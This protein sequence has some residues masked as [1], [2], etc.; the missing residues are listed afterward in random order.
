M[1]GHKI[2]LIS[3]LAVALFAGTTAEA[4]TWRRA[5]VDT[6]TFNIDAGGTVVIDAQDADISLVGE[7]TDRVE[8]EVEIAARDLER[9]Q[10]LFKRATFEATADRNSLT[11][12]AGP[13]PSRGYRSEARYSMHIRIKTPRRFDIDARTDD[14]DVSI[15]NIA[16]ALKVLSSDGDL[17]AIDIAGQTASLR[18][19]DGDVRIENAKFSTVDLK[20]SDGDIILRRVES[21]KTSAATSDGDI[22]IRLPKGMGAD[23]DLRGEDVVM[24]GVADF[25]GKIKTSSAKG[26][27]NGGG[28]RIVAK[29]KDGTVKFAF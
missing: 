9:A 14:G 6:R 8:I 26:T 22:D 16:G 1:T 24:S 10:A 29:T 27:L 17:R 13:P 28:A 7:T 2:G 12:K 4:E 11:I 3:G 20:T 18:S 21:K 5:V 19:K 25:V 23:I 15:K